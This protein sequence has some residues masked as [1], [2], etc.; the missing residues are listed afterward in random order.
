[1]SEKVVLHV[2]CG[3]APRPTEFPEA[4]WCEIRLDIDERVAP[5]VVASITDI[6]LIDGGVD[7][8]YSSHVL[9]HVF[10][11]EA[12]KALAEWYRILKPG[13]VVI[14]KVPDLQ[15]VMEA[16]LR[17]GL[18]HPLYVSDS[19]PISAV[20][21]LFG[22]RTSLA[23]GNAFYAH[24]TGF[25]GDLLAKMLTAAGFTGVDVVRLRDAYELQALA[26]K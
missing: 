22:L 21:I 20:D 24:K 17:Y 18:L 3:T 7:A 23:Q 16:A 12:E 8:V 13:G 10:F 14:L 6:P 11:H 9:E 15:S 25:T 4:D 2:G 5:H 19:G 26:K 1:M